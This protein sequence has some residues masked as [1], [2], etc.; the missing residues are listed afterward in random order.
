MKK[1]S[2]D[3][4]GSGIDHLY[5]VDVYVAEDADKRIAELEAALLF[6]AQPETYFAISFIPDRPCGMFADD[7]EETS[8]GPKPGKLARQVLGITG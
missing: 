7:F 2:A 5:G 4:I 6:Y 1:W 3:E 8:L